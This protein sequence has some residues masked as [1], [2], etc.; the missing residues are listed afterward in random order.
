MASN[1]GESDETSDTEV[2]D[3]S[4]ADDTSSDDS[5]SDEESTDDSVVPIKFNL[6]STSTAVDSEETS[7]DSSVEDG[8]DDSGSTDDGSSDEK[9]TTDENSDEVV[10]KD[11]TSTDDGTKVNP[12]YYFRTANSTTEEDTGE[13]TT[14]DATPEP[15]LYKGEDTGSDVVTDPAVTDDPQIYYMTG[16]VNDP[17]EGEPVALDDTVSTDE[18]NPDVIFYSTAGG[19][20]EDTGD[21]V[22]PTS[23][24]NVNPE[25]RTLSGGIEVTTFEG[26]V[27]LG[28][29][30]FTSAA[31]T[32]QSDLQSHISNFTQLVGLINAGLAQNAQDIAAFAAAGDT[33]GIQAEIAQNN[34][35]IQQL[36]QL[37]SNYVSGIT[38]LSQTYI[39]R[40]S[41]ASQAISQAAANPNDIG[42][43]AA[44]FTQSRLAIR[45]V[46]TNDLSAK[47]TE[48]QDLI[49]SQSGGDEGD[50]GFAPGELD[51]TG[52]DVS[53]GLRI[54]PGNTSATASISEI[55][56]SLNLTGNLDNVAKPTTGET[57]TVNVSLTNTD[58]TL[59]D[60][61]LF[62][63]SISGTVDLTGTDD[64]AEIT[65][66]KLTIE[67]VNGEEPFS[68]DV[69]VPGE[70][71]DAASF[72]ESGVLSG[73]SGQYTLPATE[74]LLP[75]G[76]TLVVDVAI[77]PTAT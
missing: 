31:E 73:L 58:D 61:P 68:I 69:N 14:T 76:G 36:T 72:D 56:M 62:V 75:N 18:S 45:P 60:E 52:G 17:V 67:G 51:P 7:D 50:Q 41:S 2:T 59:G 71:D 16:A 5:S 11:T 12:K 39:G 30:E 27:D 33:A 42:S 26:V 48:V 46:F 4:S 20:I 37:I 74:G 1:E 13:D 70:V 8:E 65:G 44:T 25:I 9:S 21:E 3:E 53:T 28:L 24:E 77:T 10:T 15:V 47:F 38:E 43:A 22:T 6:F 57:V 40:I 35:L 55:G 66:G 54:R 32:F 19:G 49:D 29:Q 23:A 34:A 63:G 64:G